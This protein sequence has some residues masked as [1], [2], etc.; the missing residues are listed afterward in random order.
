M[1]GARLRGAF[2]VLPPGGELILLGELC[3]RVDGDVEV[4][5]PCVVAAWPLGIEGRKRFAGTAV[6]ASSG[7]PVATARA[8]WIEMPAAR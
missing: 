8:T 5:E 7:A 3:A 4:G 6:L 2:T 1:G